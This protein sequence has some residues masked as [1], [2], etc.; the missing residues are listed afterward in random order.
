MGRQRTGC[1]QWSP[2]KSTWLAIL[3][4][5]GG[6]RKPVEMTGLPPH[7]A[8]CTCTPKAPC[9]ARAKAIAMVARYA[10][11]AKDGGAVSADSRHTCEEFFDAWE[12]SRDARGLR[13]MTRDRGRWR[14]WLSPHLG[15]RPIAEVTTRELEVLVASLDADVRAGKLAWK[16]AIHAWSLVTKMFDDAVRSKDLSLRMRSDNPAK[17][18]RGPDRGPN[19]ASAFLFPRDLSPLLACPTVPEWRRRIYAFATAF[20]AFPALRAF[21]ARCTWAK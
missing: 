1:A 18:V 4:L 13:C 21:Y 10:K 8:A 12:A 20:R 3:T 11:R 15:T 17:L 2:A 9:E 16:T 5:D 14:K 19:R 7:D 6:G